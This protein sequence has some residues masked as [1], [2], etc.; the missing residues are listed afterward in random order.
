M[1][2]RHHRGHV[3]FAPQVLLILHMEGLS[4]SITTLINLYPNNGLAGLEKQPGGPLILRGQALEAELA[5]RVL[6]SQGAFI[7]DLRAGLSR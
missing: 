4:S 5:V 7:L 1:R 3:E 2:A 6:R